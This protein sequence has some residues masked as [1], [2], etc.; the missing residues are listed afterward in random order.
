MRLRLG[1]VFPFCQTNIFK[2][3]NDTLTLL[4]SI[5]L[6]FISKALNQWGENY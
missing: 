4:K 5:Q 6:N 3:K 2:V 1:F